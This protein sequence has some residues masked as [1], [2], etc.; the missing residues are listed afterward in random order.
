MY[1]NTGT[2][3]TFLSVIFSS[4]SLVDLSLGSK[5]EFVLIQTTDG[6]QIQQTSNP[7][8]AFQTISLFG[9]FK[10][11]FSADE[12]MIVATSSSGISIYQRES[13]KYELFQE[14]NDAVGSLTTFSIS[15]GKNFMAFAEIGETKIWIYKRE[16]S[17][18]VVQQ[19]ITVSS[20]ATFLKITEEEELIMTCGTKLLWYKNE[21]LGLNLEGELDLGSNIL[22]ATITDDLSLIYANNLTANIL[23][24]R[25]S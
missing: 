7:T 15:T 17:K 2:N 6:L 21:G 9:G 19:T 13:E 20:G 5:G 12:K 14:I 1:G 3:F 4:H 22:K 8:E 11:S 10:A 25:T 24:E 23:L 16:G 18:Y